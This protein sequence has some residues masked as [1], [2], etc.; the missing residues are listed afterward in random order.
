[1]VAFAELR[2]GSGEENEAGASEGSSEFSGCVASG[3][4]TGILSTAG[5]SEM[6]VSLVK[7]PAIH[8]NK[9]AATRVSKSFKIASF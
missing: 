7:E 8:P 9:I 5:E 2:V 1:M 6:F 3:G 4:T